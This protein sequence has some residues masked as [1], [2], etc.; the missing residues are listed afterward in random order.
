[1]VNMMKIM[2]QAAAMRENLGKVQA[3]LARKNDGIFQRGWHGDGDSQRGRDDCLDPYRSETGRSLRRG[4]AS[5]YRA[6]GREWRDSNGQGYGR[7]GNVE[8]DGGAWNSGCDTRFA[9]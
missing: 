7:A 8:V 3:D 6:C 4:H 1:M 2:K 9:L 5:G